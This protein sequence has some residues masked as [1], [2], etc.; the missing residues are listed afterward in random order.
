M[1]I[2][3]GSG[4]G[5]GSNPNGHT[6]QVSVCSANLQAELWTLVSEKQAHAAS[7]LT[8]CANWTEQRSTNSGRSAPPI[9]PSL[10]SIVLSRS[11]NFYAAL[12]RAGAAAAAA[13]AAKKRA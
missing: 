2:S 10:F 8:N 13:A 11:L 7:E 6:T 5:I 3:G 4:S 1:T 9:E 12:Q